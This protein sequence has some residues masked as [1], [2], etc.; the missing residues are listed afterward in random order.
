MNIAGLDIDSHHLPYIVA[1]LSANHGG[2]LALAEDMCLAAR[3]AGADAVKIQC[4]TADEMCFRSETIV[5]HGLWKGENLYELY[6][7]GETTRDFVADLFHFAKKNNISLFSSVFSREGVD[8]VH[9]LGA[10]AIKIASFELTDIPLITYAASK[11]LPM[12]ISTGMGSNKEIIHAIQA[13]HKG[14]QGKVGRNLALLH[15]ISNYPA[16]PSEINLPALGVLAELMGG[17]HVV[18]FSD[19]SHGFGSAVAAV[20]FGASIIEKHFIMDRSLGG[21]DADFSLEPREFSLLVRSCRDAWLAIQSRPG[22]RES[23][24]KRYRRSVFAVAPI[25]AGEPFSTL[26]C[27]ILRGEFGVSPSSYTCILQARATQDI[28]AGT[29]LQREM[30]SSLC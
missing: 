3:D 16:N 5:D 22:H 14:S 15:C 6:K 11:G 8:F 26:N 29:P 21:L 24:M 27:R 13:Y 2:D 17:R 10:P 30:V 20:A 25:S 4:F 19:H 23:G 9:N 12:V 1:E 28:A 7:K 18:G